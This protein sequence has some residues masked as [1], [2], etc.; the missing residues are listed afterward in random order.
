MDRW[1]TG[2]SPDLIIDCLVVYEVCPLF[3][4]RHFSVL[5]WQST[6]SDVIFSFFTQHTTSVSCVVCVLKDRVRRPRSSKLVHHIDTGSPHATTQISVPLSLFRNESHCN[7]PAHITHSVSTPVLQGVWSMRNLEHAVPPL[8]ASHYAGIFI[9]LW[10]R[11]IFT[12][13]LCYCS[14]CIYH[15]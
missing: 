1:I 14:E 8:P 9:L 13:S 15:Q 3:I 2:I 5:C 10:A 4:S 7:S 11:T 12:I 6:L